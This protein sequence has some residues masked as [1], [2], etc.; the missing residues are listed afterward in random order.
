MALAATSRALRVALKRPCQL[1]GGLPDASC[2]VALLRARPTQQHRQAA[3]ALH[4]STMLLDRGDKRGESHSSRVDNKGKEEA[5]GSADQSKP[6]S[7]RSVSMTDKD[8]PDVVDLAD[9]IMS[10]TSY[11]EAVAGTEF[12]ALDKETSEEFEA[13][14][15]RLTALREN[16][17]EEYLEE[18]G[19]TDLLDKVR[20]IYGEPE[21]SE[22]TDGPV[23]PKKKKTV[24]MAQ[25]QWAE[26]LVHTDRVTKTVKGGMEIQYRALVTVGN[27]H[28]VGGFAIGKADTPAVA[29]TEASRKAKLL[30]NLV[31]VERYKQASLCQDLVGKHNGSKVYIWSRPPGSGMRAGKLSRDILYNMGI[32]DGAC[33]IIG[34]RNKYSMIYAMFD[35]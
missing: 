20:A 4:S 11:K 16:R 25:G 21:T 23:P 24:E 31:Y 13:S 3:A 1:R 9:L 6:V 15:R 32:T 17:L 22:Q 18:T 33:K 26:I 7:V 2:S 14:S 28:G 19:E 27:L 8:K 35:A 29:I 10:G 30:H 12:D 5:T 34:R